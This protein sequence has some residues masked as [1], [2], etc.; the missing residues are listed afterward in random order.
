MLAPRSEQ[1]LV[2]FH[3][4]V[5][6]LNDVVESER[7]MRN[8][9]DALANDNTQHGDLT[10]EQENRLREKLS[11]FKKDSK[12]L[13]Q[14]LIS[15]DAKIN[16]YEEAFK[17]LKEI[18]G[19]KGRNSPAV[20]ARIVKMYIDNEDENFS[21]FGY[22]QDINREIDK[23]QDL[24]LQIQEETEKYALEQ[25]EQDSKRKKSLQE[26]EA[27]LERYKKQ[28]KINSERFDQRQRALAQVCEGVEEVFEK[29]E[30]KINMPPSPG[31][32]GGQEQKGGEG[33]E[34]V[35]GGG[36]GEGGQ[37][38]GEG[39]EG[40]EEERGEREGKREGKGSGSND[41]SRTMSRSLTFPTTLH[42]GK[43]AS[44]RSL[45]KQGTKKG[46]GLKRVP[47]RKASIASSKELI[48]MSIAQG[49]DES[50]LMVCLGIIEQEAC[51]LVNGYKA[52]KLRE[53][54]RQHKAGMHGS[55]FGSSGNVLKSSNMDAML[56]PSGPTHPRRRSPKPHVEVPGS[57]VGSVSD[58]KGFSY[59]ELDE[60]D[61]D[62]F[63]DG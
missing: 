12:A 56:S 57:L 10:I 53:K 1:E 52:V 41:L 31:S 7:K 15:T 21:L 51:E 42:T 33:G 11:K 13:K 3:T 26:L 44:S 14:G 24:L 35:C 22:I 58:A 55:A 29:L 61:D 9:I 28:Y 2:D 30:C 54:H 45:K 17:Q 43:G 62:D 59:D 63:L 19:I 48:R 46:G 5:N 18:A 36:G 8:E 50:N 20:T 47:T 32:A 23:E 4:E 37:E 38:G 6:A 60:E 27:R 25:K 49:V 34:C 39:G 16:S 40:G